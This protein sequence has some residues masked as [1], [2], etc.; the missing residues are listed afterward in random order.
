MMY[1]IKNMPPK[2]EEAEAKKPTKFFGLSP[3]VISMGAVSFLNDLSS[4]MIFPFIPI[5]LT[6]TLGASATFVGLIEGV[7]DATAGVLKIV[8]GRVSDIFRT[9]KP[10]VI[11]GYSLSAISKPILSIAQAPWHVLVVRFFDRVGKGMR[12]G[13]RDTLISLSI[14]K[15]H[16]GKAFG[17]HRGADTLGA[18]IGPL[19]ATAILPIINN[20]LRSLFLLSFVASFFAVLI[21][22]AFVKEVKTETKSEKPTVK[23]DIKSLGTPFLIFLAATTIFSLGKSSE[24][25]L[26][27]R[28]Q[29]IGISLMLIPILYFAFNISLASFS[30]PV[31]TISDKVGHRNS[32][33]F[34]MI[35]SSFIYFLF[36]NSANNMSIWLLFI[37][38][39]LATAFIE[40][41]GRA[42]VS[43]LVEEKYRAT[44]YGIYNAF[45]GFALLPAS[46][47][48]G[49]IWDKS[50]PTQA[51][52]YSAFVSLIAFV[53]F[54]FL[55]LNHHRITKQF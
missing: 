23:F 53:V 22:I 50:G 49:Y 35:L 41:V 21:L 19:L 48:F 18:A 4:D 20:D 26:I 36:G 45:N 40:A 17:F 54:A 42:I 1:N 7:A 11:F 3:N 38:F 28:A 25:F 43:D 2:I 10:F 8:S 13:P 15:K 44:A 24:A 52:Y 16:L 39:G 29:N 47:I 31:G 34:G 37:F 33:M 27:L 12:D 55:R 51:F 46:I 6:T 9:R 30:G 14:D 32:F 5:F